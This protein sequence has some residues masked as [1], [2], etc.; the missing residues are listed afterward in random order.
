MRSFCVRPAVV[1]YSTL[2]PRST[3]VEIPSNTG[4][5]LCS[6]RAQHSRAQHSVVYHCRV[7]N[8]DATR[9]VVGPLQSMRR[10][11]TARRASRSR[12]RRS[13]PLW[14]ESLE[15][16]GLRPSLLSALWPAHP[17]LQHRMVHAATLHV[18]SCVP[19]CA[20]GDVE[21]GDPNCSDAHRCAPHA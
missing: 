12:T 7:C 8:A 2:Q 13:V 3:T 16:I 4:N 14:S 17:L 19:P 20:S 1:L 11:R 15:L 21:V 6:Y 5:Q 10:Q 9:S 18:A